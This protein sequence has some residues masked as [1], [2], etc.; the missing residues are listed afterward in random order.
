MNRAEFQDLA[1]MRIDEAGVLL[2]AG[3]WAGAYY[4]AGYAVECALKACIAKLTKAED[5]PPR[6]TREYYTHD[7]TKLMKTAELEGDWKARVGA[8][9][10]FKT[11]WE[12]C[13]AWEEG[14]RYERP[15][16]AQARDLYQAITDPANGV[17]QWIRGYW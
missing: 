2:A 3:K 14:S 16:E 6:E 8:D 13:E 10:G 17:L 7:I 15:T 12:G 1:E 11:Y 9:P 4:L 5:F